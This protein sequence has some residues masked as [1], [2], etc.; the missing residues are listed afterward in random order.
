MQTDLLIVELNV[1]NRDQKI[2]GASMSI[3]ST[4]GWDL[5]NLI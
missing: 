3:I 1:W 2:Q 5:F 4:Q